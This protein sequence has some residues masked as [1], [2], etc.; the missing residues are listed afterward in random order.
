MTKTMLATMVALYLSA[1]SLM[2]KNIVNIKITNIKSTQG[3][4]HI[5][6]YKKNQN[7]PDH[8][9]KHYKK[10]VKPKIG[11][12]NIVIDDLQNE[13]YAIAVLHDTNGNDHIDTNFLGMPKEPFAF[14][15]N[16]KPILSAPNFN[17]CK[18]NLNNETK[19]FTINLID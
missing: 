17:D 14:S 16:F 11:C 12:I 3:K 7:F 6:V 19:S 2:A 13:D 8:E 9:S 15:K 1:N 18:F 10:V 5:G 4:I